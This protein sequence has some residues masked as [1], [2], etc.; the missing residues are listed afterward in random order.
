MTDLFF[1]L[2]SRILQSFFG[3]LYTRGS[4]F[5]DLVAWLVSAGA[6]VSWTN[7][8]IPFLIGETVFEIGHG[9]GHLLRRLR[10][11]RTGLLVGL[12]IS[13]KMS[14]AASNRLGTSN[15]NIPLVTGSAS[16]I[17]LN[18]AIFDSVVTTFPAPEIFGQQSISEIYRL[19]RPGGRWI[20]LPAV[21]IE[22]TG[23]WSLI[24]FILLGLTRQRPMENLAGAIQHIFE[25]FPV[26]K[27]R[28]EEVPIKFGHA[29]V[30]L[31]EK[32]RD[33]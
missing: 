22:P 28:I 5:Y 24:P 14:V 18:P 12:D 20:C 27:V 11:T 19:L 3:W 17:P 25:G 29:V 33:S 16:A 30:I 15:H 21:Q 9:P 1:G 26:F 7:S 8:V 2:I 13:L 6:W 23:L 10:A 4:A 32:S 31:A